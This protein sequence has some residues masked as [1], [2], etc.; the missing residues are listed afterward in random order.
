ML[1]VIHLRKKKREI[2]PKKNRIN[3]TW[4]KKIEKKSE[5]KV[6][7]KIDSILEIIF[8]YAWYF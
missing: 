2:K 4:K 3:L 1:S 8:R 6:H 7:Q 5:N